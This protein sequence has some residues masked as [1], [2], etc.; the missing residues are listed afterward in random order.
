MLRTAETGFYQENIER[1]YKSFKK[2]T[3]EGYEPY[4]PINE[5]SLYFISNDPT[6]ININ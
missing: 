4:E 6:R 1:F 2:H 5:E 3:G